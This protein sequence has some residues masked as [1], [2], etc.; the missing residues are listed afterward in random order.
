MYEA[1]RKFTH[2]MKNWHQVFVIAALISHSHELCKVHINTLNFLQYDY[3]E[4]LNDT[5]FLDERILVV[6]TNISSISYIHQHINSSHSKH[7]NITSSHIPTIAP[8]AFGKFPE[9]IKLYLSNIHI[10]TI[11]EGAFDNLTKLEELHLD[12]NEIVEVKSQVFKDLH[13]LK[14]LYLDNNR[15]VTVDKTALL[16]V[17]NLE[18]LNLKNNLITRI[19]EELL[20]KQLRLRE[21]DLSG[22]PIK[23]ISHILPTSLQR[24]YLMKIPLSEINFNISYLTLDTLNVKYGQLSKIDCALLPTTRVLD[25]SDN[26]ISTI[27]NLQFLRALNLNLKNN[28]IR[29]IDGVFPSTVSSIQ[30]SGNKL[31]T[32]ELPFNKSRKLLHLQISS[33]KLSKIN[34]NAFE[35]LSALLS[36]TLD[37]NNITT[38][39][40]VWFKD[41]IYLVNLNLSHNNIEQ[42]K[43]GTFDSLKDLEILDLSYN[44]ITSLD[45]LHSLNKLTKLYFDGNQISNLNMEEMRMSFRRLQLLSLDKNSFSCQKLIKIQHQLKYSGIVIKHGTSYH[46]DHFH[47]ILC[48][49]SKN[50]DTSVSS[51]VLKNGSVKP[52]GFPDFFNG[53][54]N[55]TKFVQ[56]FEDGY[57][58]SNFFKSLN[59]TS[60]NGLLIFSSVIQLIVSILLLVL[61]GF[62]FFYFKKVKTGYRSDSSSLMELT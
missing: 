62:I 55:R 3:Y 54:F 23:N 38:V 4:D 5:D 15:I 29:M 26:K 12:H 18:V 41:L 10:K 8:Q 52:S 1:L 30:I 22:N 6:C 25:L 60:N 19:E 16:G 34:Q 50:N 58:S 57:R 53:D 37:N 49:N 17:D 32:L 46:S 42:F 43:F 47:G 33:N 39:E 7:L 40:R 9:L 56:F 36:L 28:N 45:T 51:K 27:A 21:L 31:E 13:Q 35:G 2:K 48:N 61:I 24:L 14:V 59:E 20:V 44:K 11:L